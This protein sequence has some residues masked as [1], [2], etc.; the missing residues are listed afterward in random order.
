V[1]SLTLDRQAATVL[2][3]RDTLPLEVATIRFT[4]MTRQWNWQHYN[5]LC[6]K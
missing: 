5:P 2:I 1:V 6:R 4:G 3:A